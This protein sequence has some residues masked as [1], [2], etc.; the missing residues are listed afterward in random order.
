MVQ[1]TPQAKL[2]GSLELSYNVSMS[3]QINIKHLA[4]LGNIKL[5]KKEESIFTAEIENILNF[6]NK[7]QNINTQ[8][9]L[10]T[11]Q[12]TDQ[13]NTSRQDEKKSCLPIKEVLNNSPKSKE[14]YIQVPRVMSQ[15][16]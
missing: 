16:E 3:D 5:S 12:V 9:T 4:K 1:F 11:F 8:N 6:I 2:D 13:K 7:I 10:P 15:D 14:G